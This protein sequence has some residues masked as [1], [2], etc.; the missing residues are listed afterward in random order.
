MARSRLIRR[1]NSGDLVPQ[2]DPTKLTTEAAQRAADQFRREIAGLRELI[3][4]RSDGA[5]NA[6]N[7]RIDAME[8]WTALLA[9]QHPQLR[10]ELK[11][12]SGQFAE[13]L[14]RVRREIAE[15][16]KHVREEIGHLREINNE[17]FRSVELQFAERDIRNDRQVV[18]AQQ[19][20]ETALDT[21]RALADQQNAANAV[22]QQKSE[23]SFTKQIDQIGVQITTL[24]GS[25]QDRITE[26]KERIDRGEGSDL[27]S[28]QMRDE[29]RLDITGIIQGISVVI[30][31]ITVLVIIFVNH[32]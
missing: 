8:K 22:A 20:I 3:D 10:T 6:V 17:K 25:L 23:A 9:E 16:I 4:I 14:E 27:G 30:A 31:F 1:E 29:H 15:E 5:F 18:V 24:A 7:I 19:A 26:I 28:R 13:V 2:P 32:K 11:Q 12:Q 21:A